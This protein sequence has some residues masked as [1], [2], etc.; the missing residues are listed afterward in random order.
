[1]DIFNTK[2]VKVLED[3]ISNLGKRVDAL[4]EAN[5]TA[6]GINI[7]ELIKQIDLAKM[8]QKFKK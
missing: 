4:E 8:K 5:R 1:M 3:Y 2:K 6:K 7:D